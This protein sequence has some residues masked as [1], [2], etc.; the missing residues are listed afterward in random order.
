MSGD[1][2]IKR[3]PEHVRWVTQVKDRVRDV[4][5]RLS[6]TPPSTD[7]M[8][9][10]DAKSPNPFHMRELWLLRGHVVIESTFEARFIRALFR[11]AV[12]NIPLVDSLCT[13][14]TTADGDIVL[15]ETC[16]TRRGK[17]PI[18]NM[19]SQI[20]TLLQN[21]WADRPIHAAHCRCPD[22][23]HQ[24]LPLSY[25]SFRPET[26]S[27]SGIVSKREH[28]LLY[29]MLHAYLPSGNRTGYTH[30]CNWEER[31]SC[32]CYPWTISFGEDGTISFRRRSRRPNDMEMIQKFCPWTVRAELY[33]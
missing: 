22:H 28:E 20:D 23:H 24:H 17:L 21:M 10:T 12:W 8:Y 1:A 27:N 14:K 16:Y 33:T 5:I 29:L 18:E 26:F 6:T 9:H 25:S 30:E 19:I 13:L 31:T 15:Y 7:D 4:I 3:S 2:D 11:R 32:I